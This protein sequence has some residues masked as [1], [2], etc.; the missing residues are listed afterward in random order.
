MD[1]DGDE[2][3]NLLGGVQPEN[4]EHSVLQVALLDQLC[5]AVIITDLQGQILYWN[6]YAELLCQWQA[7]EIVDHPIARILASEVSPRRVLR[8]VT[9]LRR[10]QRWKGK[11]PLQR[12]DGSLRWMDVSCS[13]LNDSQGVV[14]GYIGVCADVTIERQQTQK[15][16]QESAA[17]LEKRERFLATLV[18]VQRQLLASTDEDE[19]YARILS[20][21]GHASGASRVYVFINHRSASGK[22]LTSQRAEWCAEGI[23]SEI[24]N[25]LLQNVDYNTNFPRWVEVLARGNPISGIVSEFPEPEQAVLASQGILS[26]LVLPLIVHGTFFGSIGFDNCSTACIW[27][28]ATIDLLAAS[29]AALSLG[30]ER[31]QM[32]NDLRTSEA[33]YR[34]I[35][36]DQTDLVCRFLPDTTLTFVNG[37]YCRQFGKRPQELVGQSLLLLV[38]EEYQDIVRQRIAALSAEDPVITDENPCWAANGEVRWIQWSNRAIFDAHGQFVEYQSVG[39]DIT[40]ERRLRQE[41][42][43]AQLQLQQQADRERLLSGIATRIRQSLDLAE[44]LNRTVAEV[45]QFL[46]TDRVL[47]YCL[48]SEESGELMA[49][50]VAPAWS[51]DAEIEVHNVWYRYSQATSEQRTT[52]V[53]NDRAAGALSAHYLEFLQQIQVQAKLIVPILHAD[54]F[55][56]VLLVHQCTGPRS[57]Q[58]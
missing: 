36:E 16:L 17:A 47:I 27:E 46:Q 48:N 18:E 39:R 30:L 26:I 53:L 51:L 34:A 4:L 7:A 32:E 58:P 6:R 20:L 24:N 13:V 8:I 9:T 35:V 29:A 14:I 23:T 10:V 19:M 50:S 57:W 15:A 33:R 11:L 41:R 49:A 28:T 37:A 55:W 44:I 40:E 43:R 1:S 3:H 31:R 52:Y 38:V 22:L 54:R 21:L 5:S 45:R 42:Q 12:K 25:P 2:I 56:G